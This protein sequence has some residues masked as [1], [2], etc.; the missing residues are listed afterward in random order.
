MKCSHHFRWLNCYEEE[1]V[2]S[3]AA[4][5]RPLPR[6]TRSRIRAVILG[7]LILMCGIV[8]G[9]GITFKFLWDSVMCASEHPKEMHIRITDRLKNR[10]DLTD[11]QAREVRAVIVRRYMARDSLRREFRPLVEAEF[12]TLRKEVEAV[13]DGEQVRR[14]NELYGTMRERW[15]RPLPEE[16]TPAKD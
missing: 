15:L 3:D 14:W 4:S 12:E 1:I 7:F 5:L 10:L 11:E 16:E 13:L 9:S 2:K 8:I 6:P